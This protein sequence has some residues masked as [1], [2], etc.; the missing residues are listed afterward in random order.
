MESVSISRAIPGPTA[1]LHEA[2]HDLEPFMKSAGFDT[3][4][5][6]SDQFTIENNVGLLSI[7]LDL[8][9][10]DRDADLAYEQIDGIFE[11]METRY[12]LE[13]GEET[14]TVT[15]T[16][17]FELDASIVGPILDA[18]II[19]RQRKKE[20][21]RQFDYLEEVAAEANATE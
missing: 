18:T 9:L 15:A 11:S 10:V 2:M 21:T 6:D 3:V 14:T 1:P 16:T 20:L 19:A 4:T 7:S 13:E 5:V 12:T 17:E 8:Q